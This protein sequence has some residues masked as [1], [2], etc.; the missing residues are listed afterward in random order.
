MRPFV[1]DTVPFLHN[2]I[3]EGKHIL[4]EGAQSAIL[5]IDFGKCNLSLINHIG[6]VLVSVLTSSAVNRGF[7]LRTDQTKDYRA[8]ICSFSAN[9]TAQKE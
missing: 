8:G 1:K 4:I 6:D 2:A 3:K 5:D 9:N 7:K